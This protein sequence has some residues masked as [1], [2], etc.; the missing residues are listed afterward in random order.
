MK[1][2]LTLNLQ[3][4]A[5]PNLNVQKTSQSSMAPGMKTFYD[6]ALLENAR[7]N[8]I[9]NQ[10]GDEQPLPKNNGN[11]IEWRKFDTFPKA[12]T[13]LTE[14]VNPDGSN[15]GMTKIEA[16]CTQHGDYTTISDRL[17]LEAVD[18]VIYAATEEMGAAGSA[19]LDTLTRNVLVAGTNVIYA[20]KSTGETVSSRATLDDTSLLTR[21]VVKKCATALK[22]AKAPKID[23][24]YVAIIHPSVAEDLRNDPAWEEAH[25][26][27]ATTEIF[28]G[29]IGEL[30]GVRFVETTEAKIW[31][32]ETGPSGKA[33]YATLF[34]GAK[35]YGVIKPE[36]A[37]MKMII[38]PA[39]E[40]GGPLELYSTVGYK[41][42]HGAKILYPE[43]L[44]RVESLS[45][46]SDL[47]EAN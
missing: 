6:T 12:L 44:I 40:A 36:G 10:F 22:K 29:E 32:D 41:F 33:V 43:R 26:Y 23:G 35:S 25:K 30:D 42:K 45:A 15:F 11:K 37:D 39:E 17:D 5:E 1:N 4:F 24:K 19:T 3:L 14:G 18:D 38:H 13:P 7:A 27:A 9:F 31:K 47:D 16:E 8:L 34:F 21:A 28:N 46:Y 20:P 2:I